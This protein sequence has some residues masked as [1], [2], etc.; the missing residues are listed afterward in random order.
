MEVAF[1]LYDAAIE[2]AKP[3][4]KREAYVRRA[5]LPLMESAAASRLPMWLFRG[6]RVAAALRL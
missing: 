4:G 6:A 1:A 3:E 5:D 2:Q